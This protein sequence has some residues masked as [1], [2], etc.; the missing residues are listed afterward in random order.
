MNC[1]WGVDE[2][3]Y[4]D[5]EEFENGRWVTAKKKVESWEQSRTHIEEM[6]RKTMIGK[7]DEFCKV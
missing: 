6:E 1:I 2:E 4:Y 5:W 3:R 7:L